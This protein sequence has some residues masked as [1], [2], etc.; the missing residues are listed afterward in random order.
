MCNCKLPKDKQGRF[1]VGEWLVR[2]HSWRAS[3]VA[4]HPVGHSVEF[5]T[6]KEVLKYLQKKL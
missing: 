4:D 3:W 5:G 1:I 6:L 2:R